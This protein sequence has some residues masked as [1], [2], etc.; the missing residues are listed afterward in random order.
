MER[1]DFIYISCVFV[2]AL[3][4]Q[5]DVVVEARVHRMDKLALEIP[6][7]WPLGDRIRATTTVEDGIASGYLGVSI[8]E[9]VM[10]LYEGTEGNEA[11]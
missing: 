4:H 6:R 7:I 5:P 8:D 9:E 1:M 2:R 10:I 11:G 3:M